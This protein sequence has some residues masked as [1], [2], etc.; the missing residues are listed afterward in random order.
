MDLNSD[1]KIC[2]IWFNESDFDWQTTG[3]LDELT[4]VIELG[5]WE[6]FVS[7]LFF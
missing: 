3:A 4:S 6:E 5:C 7:A 1:P 2:Q